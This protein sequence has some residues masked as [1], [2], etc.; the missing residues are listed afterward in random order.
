MSNNSSSSGSKKITNENRGMVDGSDLTTKIGIDS[1]EIKWRKQYTQFS[2]QDAN[3]LQ[4]VS[5][6]FEDIADELV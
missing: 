5:H 2:K 6:I 1:E 3:A 4:S